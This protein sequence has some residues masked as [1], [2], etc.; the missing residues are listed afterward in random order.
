MA[1]T[2]DNKETND[3][4]VSQATVTA[5]VSLPV[6]RDETTDYVEN[7]ARALFPDSRSQITDAQVDGF[8]VALVSPKSKRA[9]NGDAAWL[10]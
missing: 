3:D 10:G 7:V 4:V 2:S 1:R 6:R 5:A 9:P 8:L